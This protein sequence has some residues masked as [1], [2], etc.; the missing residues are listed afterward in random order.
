M[1]QSSESDEDASR[2]IRAR[3]ARM[4]LCIIYPSLCVTKFVS[5]RWV[6]GRCAVFK[7]ESNNRGRG[8]R[9]NVFLKRFNLPCLP[10]H[11]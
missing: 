11:I 2:T 8:Q 6:T 5:Y 7:M 1:R 3:N 4:I 9:A 10:V